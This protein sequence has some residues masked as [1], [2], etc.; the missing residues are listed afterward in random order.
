[1]SVVQCCPYEEKERCKYEI[2]YGQPRFDKCSTCN[3]MKKKP[4]EFELLKQE[5]ACKKMLQKGIEEFIKKKGFKRM[6][7]ILTEQEY[8][9]LIS[10]SNQNTNWELYAHDLEKK[11][12]DIFNAGKKVMFDAMHKDTI[13]YLRE[14]GFTFE[15]IETFISILRQK[16]NIPTEFNGMFKI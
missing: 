15:D 12:D 13:D 6:Q 1:M 7:I 2:Y 16:H 11:I 4:A 10:Q 9:K 5:N 8:N 14:K 3:R